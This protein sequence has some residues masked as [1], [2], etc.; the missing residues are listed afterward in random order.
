MPDGDIEEPRV[1]AEPPQKRKEEEEEEEDVSSDDTNGEGE[2]GQIEDG[3]LAESDDDIPNV[4]ENKEQAG[5]DR[6]QTE[7]I[8]RPRFEVAPGGGGG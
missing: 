7:L 1:E 5:L 8:N 2:D 4:E 3:I 6:S